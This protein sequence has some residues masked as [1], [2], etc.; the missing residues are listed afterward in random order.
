MEFADVSLQGLQN[1]QTQILNLSKLLEEYRTHSMQMVKV[2]GQS[3]RDQQF[4]RFV[5][6]FASRQDALKIISESYHK[7]AKGPLQNTIDKII[8]YDKSLPGTD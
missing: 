8:E 7:W 1:L 3:W 6:S 5:H 2:V 4:D